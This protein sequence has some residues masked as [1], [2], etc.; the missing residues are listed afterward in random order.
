MIGGL[1]LENG[2][3]MAPLR[4]MVGGAEPDHATADDEDVFGHWFYWELEGEL[5]SE[6]TLN[7]I[8]RAASRPV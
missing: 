7:R 5:S 4:G 2:D 6:A 8:T 1:A 3:A